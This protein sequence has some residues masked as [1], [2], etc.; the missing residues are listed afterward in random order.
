MAVR[1]VVAHPDAAPRPTAQ[2]GHVG[3]GGAF[4]DE[5]QPVR[6]LAHPGLTPPRPVRPRRAHVGALALAGDQRFF[7]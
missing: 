6:L 1:G 4:V 7:L 2:P 3:L 5:D